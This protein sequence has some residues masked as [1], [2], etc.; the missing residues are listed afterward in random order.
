MPIQ[1][2]ISEIQSE[3]TGV[4]EQRRLAA[5]NFIEARNTDLEATTRASYVDANAEF[6]ASSA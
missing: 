6:S 1:L 4:H 3:F 2:F 5:L